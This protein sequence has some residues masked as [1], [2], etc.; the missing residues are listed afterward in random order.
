MLLLSNIVQHENIKLSELAEYFNSKD[1]REAL[2]LLCIASHL[3]TL[4]RIE[5]IIPFE[6]CSACGV[7]ETMGHAI[8]SRVSVIEANIKRI[9]DLQAVANNFECFSH[10]VR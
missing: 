8:V 6:N 3:D 4:T 5:Q 7:L 1:L 10:C 2:A 9:F